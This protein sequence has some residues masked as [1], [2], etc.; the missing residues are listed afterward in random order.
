MKLCQG[1]HL[2]WAAGVLKQL[3]AKPNRFLMLLGENTFFVRNKAPRRALLERPPG[4]RVAATAA[5]ANV[6]DMLL[7]TKH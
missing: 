7:C 5:Y 4:C 2:M 6:F 1:K 3:L